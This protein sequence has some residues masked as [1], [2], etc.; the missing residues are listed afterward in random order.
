MSK[1]F[2]LSRDADKW[3]ADISKHYVTKFDLY[4]LCLMVGFASGRKADPDNATDLIDNYPKEFKPVGR[5][6][7]A[8]L[9]NAEL[10]S[11][12]ID[13]NER[14]AVYQVIGEIIDPGFPTLLSDEGVKL[15][16]KYAQGGYEAM[17][18]YFDDR[19]RAVETF[20][21]KYSNCIEELEAGAFA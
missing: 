5:L 2:Q 8:L 6:L 10:K 19:P 9:L 4:Y 21:R 15:M 20:A 3:F 12:G 17:Y 7:V 18:E 1:Y 13:L 11:S 16:N 14:D